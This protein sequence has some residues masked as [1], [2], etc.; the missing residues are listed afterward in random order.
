MENLGKRSII[1]KKI[2]SGM[3]STMAAI[4]LLVTSAN[5][6]TACWFVLGQDELPKQAKKLRGF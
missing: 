1:L 2:R 3:L 6:S 5:V 4:A